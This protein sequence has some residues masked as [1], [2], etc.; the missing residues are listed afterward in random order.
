MCVCVCLC[1]CV[2]ICVCICV[3][4]WEREN[5][6]YN[7][8]SLTLH[9]KLRSQKYTSSNHMHYLPCGVGVHLRPMPRVSALQVTDATAAPSSESAERETRFHCEK[10][11]GCMT[12]NYLVRG[13]WA[14]LH[15][16]RGWPPLQVLTVASTGRL[17]SSLHHKQ[18]WYILS[19]FQYFVNKRNVAD[20]LDRISGLQSR[21][22]RV[23]IFSGYG[24]V[25]SSRPPRPP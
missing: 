24:H 15:K 18:T 17:L 5:V 16:N 14:T 8:W 23:W 7:L 3:C 21:G 9:F 12:T 13:Q 10:Y 19:V 1:V 20:I 6:L 22:W 11:C 25:N 4:V 2:C